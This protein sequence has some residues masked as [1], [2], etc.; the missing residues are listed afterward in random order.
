MKKKTVLPMFFSAFLVIAAVVVL[1]V[2]ASPPGGHDEKV[3]LIEKGASAGS[4]AALLHEEGLVR[5]PALFQVLLRLSG[6]D[7]KIQAGRYRMRQGLRLAGIIDML[8]KGEISRIQVTIPEGS[9]MKAIAMLLDKSG[10]CKNADFL[11]AANDAALAKRAGIPASRFEGFLFPDTYFFPEGG[12]AESIIATMTQNFFKKLALIAGTEPDPKTLFDKVTL[13]SIVEREYRVPSEAALI[14]SVFANRL[15]IGMA[16]QSCATVVYVMTEKQNKPHPSVVHYSDLEIRDPYN[17]YLHRGLP[18]G[19]ISNPGE[20]ALRAVF[21]PQ[22]SDYLYFRLMDVSSGR[23]R[24][25]QTF[26]E[27]AQESI[28]V[29]GF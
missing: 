2:V 16:L 12:S 26:E 28:P 5:S 25:S 27:H 9:T 19:P 7:T 3:V 29:K 1:S 8:R 17:T 10:V 4:V 23:H 15:R 14:A 13:A 20:T 24:F 6:S 22:K 21:S 18:P 11:L